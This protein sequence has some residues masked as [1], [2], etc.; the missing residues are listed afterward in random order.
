MTSAP[1]KEMVVLYPGNKRLTLNDKTFQDMVSHILEKPGFKEHEPLCLHFPA[2]G[3]YLVYQK[4]LFNSYLSGETSQHE[5]IE[6]TSCD[7]LYRNKNIMDFKIGGWIDAGSLWKRIGQI[8]VL[9]TDDE[10]IAA[11]YYEGG[12]EPIK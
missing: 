6:A 2:T 5:L 12:F 9:V 4:E 7:G 11:D 1:I 3:K 8:M 10:H